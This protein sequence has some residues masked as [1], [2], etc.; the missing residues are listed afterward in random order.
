REVGQG[1]SQLVSSFP[2]ADED[3]HVSVAPLDDLLKQD[4]L[5]G[6]ETPRH[7]RCRPAG[8][9][10]EQVDDPLAAHER[11]ERPKTLTNGPRLADRPFLDQGDG[12]IAHRGDW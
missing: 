6:A 4:R 11:Y 5:T 12:Q 8:D 9:G 1:V 10:E 3:D 7:C 2:T